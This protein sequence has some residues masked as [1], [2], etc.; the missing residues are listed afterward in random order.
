MS[1]MSCI[2]IDSQNYI[3]L[4]DIKQYLP[5]QTKHILAETSR[6]VTLNV[7]YLLLC[8][9]L[10]SRY[11][12]MT[13]VLLH[14][15]QHTDTHLIGATEQLQT[16]LMLGTDLSV[17]VANFIHQLVPFKGGRL[18][19]GLE[20][21]LAV[22]GQ[23]HEAGLNGFVFLADAHVTAHILGSC[24]VVVRRRRWRRKGFT[25]ALHG[26]VSRASY[27]SWGG[28]LVVG[29]SALG[30]EVRAC[31]VCV[32]PVCLQANGAKDVTTWDWHGIPEVLL[33]QVAAVL[34]RWHGDKWN[35]V[36]C[37]ITQG[38][39]QTVSGSS[40][41]SGKVSPQL[42]HAQVIKGKQRG[43]LNWLCRN[44]SN[45]GGATK[46][47]SKCLHQLQNLIRNSEMCSHKAWPVEQKKKVS[48]LNVFSFHLPSRKIQRQHIWY[49]PWAFDKIWARSS[50]QSIH[51]L[52]RRCIQY[53]DELKP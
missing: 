20:M 52:E 41:Q 30:A 7:A 11:H 8:P 17:Q 31:V 6:V 50:I 15:A 14:C 44:Q 32:V 48:L 10:L 26:R 38:E 22:G 24:V 27:A 43:R 29:D 51:Y 47:Y 34:F 5:S 23:T 49:W 25:V 53:M 12:V 45:K 28:P 21:L 33:T 3:R 19:V 1:A 46:A 4:S 37:S 18:I 13:L 35:A 9:L 39:R 40:Q 16:L 42:L 36:P 2:T